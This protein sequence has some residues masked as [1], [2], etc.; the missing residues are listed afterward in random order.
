MNFLI[1]GP[2]HSCTR[3][4]V[5]ILDRHINSNNI[6]HWSIP[7]GVEDGLSYSFPDLSLI[8][9]YDRLIIVNRDSNAIDKS[10]MRDG[11]KI[12]FVN[13]ANNLSQISKKMIYENILDLNILDKCVFISIENLFD[14][15]SLY[16]RKVL[17]EVGL[18]PKN[19]DYDL[20]GT[21]VFNPPRW[22]SVNLD[23]SDSNRKYL[24]SDTK[25][26]KKKKIKK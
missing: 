14:Y 13:D 11:V 20:K 9:E 15:K 1:I 21:Y 23:I 5:A 26:N 18:D 19:Y 6:S 25:V 8:N 16:I 7:G 10:N 4:I 22:F 2:Q 3:L 17:E 24:N 12:D